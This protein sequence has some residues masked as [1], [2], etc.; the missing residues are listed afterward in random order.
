MISLAA[1]QTQTP[2]PAP[3][4]PPAQGTKGSDQATPPP[5]AA[6]D[7]PP[8]P[9]PTQA[10][11]KTG[12]EISLDE[13]DRADWQLVQP[14][15][16]LL[17]LDGYFRVRSD[18]LRRINFGN[19]SVTEWAGTALSGRYIVDGK[20][21][22]FTTTNMRLRVEPTINVSENIHLV[23]TLDLLD[24]VQLGGQGTTFFTYENGRQGSPI[25][26][27]SRGQSTTQ[28]GVN[29]ATDAL[30]VRRVYAR[31]TALNDQLELRVGRMPSEWGLGM[32]SNAGNCLD[33]DFGDVVDRISVS[34]KLAD[35]IFQPMYDWVS[36]GP[37]TNP[38]GRSG[39]QPL[40]AVDWDDVEQY[41]IR[42]M[43]LD[44]PAT[45]RERVAAGQTVLNYGLW[46][47]WRRQFRD[48]ANNTTNYPA[49]TTPG[50]TTGASSPTTSQN[51]TAEVNPTK[52]TPASDR[53]DSN[54]FTVD[55]YLK[56]WSGT[57]EIGLEVAGIYGTFQYTD[58][59]AADPKN[60]IENVTM[61]Q[62]GG[63]LEATMHFKGEYEG[64][65][66]SLKTGAAS[67]D[68]SPGFGALDYTTTQFGHNR[69]VQTKFDGNMTNFQFSPDYHVDLLLFR[70]VVGTVTDAWYV[71][72]EI[73]YLF[74]NSVGGKFGV[75]Y[76]QS[77]Y[78]SSTYNGMTNTSGEG[79]RP[80]GIEVDGEISYGLIGTAAE[81]GALKASFAGGILFPLNGFRAGDKAGG[82][83]GSFAWT[84]QS[85][86][87]ITF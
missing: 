5:A 65:T 66:L 50:V 3:P 69:I 34:F 40:D 7:L 74:G 13:W 10:P 75:L 17:E 67:G 23:T 20:N 82:D 18:I 55:G 1:A 53:R 22:D 30:V 9:A 80:L 54:I 35:L 37:V 68:V 62:L 38:W 64:L 71:K 57:L 39:G 79:A 48:L 58:P 47:I 36:S 86:L 24:N 14:K 28:K 41:S 78:G 12:D 16:S 43:K 87:Y 31:L 73:S 70:Q 2:P 76:A 44:S 81:A 27:L 6:P 59:S 60:A 4:A 85:R 46:G 21:A 84:L 72:P 83:S 51:T 26:L 32:F 33:C 25:S 29:S 15:T 52:G 63:A 56:L 42:M 19:G 49:T 45:I 77:I 61:A 11:A 8:P